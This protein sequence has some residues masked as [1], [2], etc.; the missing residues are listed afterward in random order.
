MGH[1]DDIPSL[2]ARAAFLMQTA[3]SVGYPNAVMEAMACGRAVVATDA[4]EAPILVD[5]G[6]TG[7][8]VP[9]N[10]N[11]ALVERMERLIAGR[12]ICRTMGKA[13]RAKMEQEFGLGRLVEETLAVYR[14]SGWS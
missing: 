13:G 9:R 12:D 14:S 7:F 10:D 1:I 6:K 4:G 5:D 8:I 2:L 11:S 3:D